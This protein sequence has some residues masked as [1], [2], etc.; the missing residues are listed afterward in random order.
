MPEPLTLEKLRALH[1]TA[2]HHARA[3]H[4]GP[5]PAHVRAGSGL[6]RWGGGFAVVQDDV[7][8]VALIRGD[9]VSLVR[10]LPH[11]ENEGVKAFK[12]D[13]EAATVLPDGRL[14]VIGSGSSAGPRRKRMV[15]LT[16]A[17]AAQVFDASALYEAFAQ[18]LGGAELNI[19]G[20]FVLGDAVIFVQRGNGAGGKNALCEVEL[21]GLVDWLDGRRRDAPPIRRCAGLVLGTVGGVPLGLTDA[22]VTED[23][24]VFVLVGAEDSP[25]AYRDGAILGAWLGRLETRDGEGGEKTLGVELFA[26]HDGDGLTKLKLEGLAWLGR[27]GRQDRFA[28]VADQD[29]PEVPVVWGELVLG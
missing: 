18:A 16:T 20:V 29:D 22:T 21:A 8:G 15:T 11:A 6:V 26:I 3:P 19:E 12:A 7:G 14:L 23:G 4:P 13:F 2:D 25:D 28:V 10:L 1:Y 9:E 17:F 27:E 24:R 5:R